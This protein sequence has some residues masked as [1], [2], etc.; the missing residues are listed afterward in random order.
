MPVNLD[1]LKN[2]SIAEKLQFIEL[3]CRDIESSSEPIPLKRES[4]SL[5]WL[6]SPAR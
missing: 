3:L 1:A 5:N 4:P 6:S 2:L